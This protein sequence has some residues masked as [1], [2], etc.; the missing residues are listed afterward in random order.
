MYKLFL[1][2][3]YLTRK[4]IVLFPILAVWLCVMMLI[5]VYSIMTGF[6]N[7]V[8]DAGRGLMG[9]IVIDCRSMSGFPYYAAFQQRL[10]KLPAVK[11]S[12]P[13]IYAYGLMNLPEFGANFGV[14]IV[15]I[16]AVGKSEVSTFRK[17]L[18]RQ[19]R[20]PLLALRILGNTTFPATAARLRKTAELYDLRMRK[21]ARAL[22]KKI[23]EEKPIAGSGFYANYRRHWRQVRRSDLADVDVRI[24]RAAETEDLLYRI[25]SKRVFKS[26]AALKEALLPAQPTFTPPPQAALRYPSAA[27]EPKHGCIVGVDI[28]LYRHDRNGHYR[29]DPML[30]YA[31]AVIT[32]APIA[33]GSFVSVPP[34]A[35]T[36]AI[37]DDSDTKVFDV[38]STYVYAPFRVVQKMAWMQRRPLAEGSGHRPARCSEIEVAIHHADNPYALRAA[39]DKIAAMLRA[40]RRRHPQMQ[41]IPMRVQTWQQKQGAYIKAVENERDIITFLLGMMSM[42]VVIVIFL[43]FYMIVRDKTRD[44]GIIKAV[45]GS[46]LGVASIF[47]TYGLFIGLV[48]GALGVVSGVEFVLHDNWIHNEILQRWFGVTIWNR[49]VYLFSRIPSQVRASDVMFIFAAALVAGILGA[50]VPAF[51]AGRQDPVK[52]LRYE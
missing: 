32:V 39:R 1:C 23:G 2:L 8:R 24:G 49:K 48:G 52:S 44:I 28:G 41:T 25:P 16:H 13:V 36:F 31:K 18:Y 50:V 42:V 46:E 4:G 11:T 21:K 43:I 30:S 35:R 14:Q 34:E 15:G 27:A 20:L 29:R 9:D 5:V 7:R 17:S 12:T 10:R 37:V 3:R 33:R 40:F 22:A 45:G 51:I 6:V 26:I 19:Y 38:D 47:T